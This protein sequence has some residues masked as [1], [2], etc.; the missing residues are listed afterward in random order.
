MDLHLYKQVLDSIPD[1]VTVQDKDFNVI[2]QNDAMI[3]AFGDCVGKKCY[4]CYEKRDEICDGCGVS[5]AFETK[6]TTIV[7]RTAFEKDGSTSYWE[8]ACEPLFDS[9]GNIIAGVE[10]CRNITDRVSLESAVKER[11]IKLGQVNKQLKNQTVSLES[12]M[13]EL[14]ETQAQLIELSRQA[15][16]AEVAVGILH[17]LGNSLNSVNVSVSFILEKLDDAQ[18]INLNKVIDLLKEHEDDIGTF[19]K[20]D[21]KGKHVLPFLTS[22]GNHICG[23]QNAIRTE[24]IGLLKNIEHIKNIVLMQQDYASTS[25]FVEK[26]DVKEL[27]EDALHLTEEALVRHRVPVNRKYEAVPLITVHKHMVLQILVNLIN[28]AKYAM[29]E[30]NAELRCM[31]ICVGH[32]QNGSVRIS[33][34]DSGI[35][36]EKENL[37]KIFSHGF[38]TRK[39]GH[40]FGLHVSALIA[41]DLGGSLTGYSDGVGK[42]ATFILEL[43]VECVRKQ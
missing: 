38:T 29:D 30:I 33:V 37:T 42:G 3:N 21:D 11:N 43:P 26:V 12:A 19:I 13:A 28:N 10:I 1:G 35:G 23:E 22:L 25:G 39:S 34:S 17:N 31:D 8:N 27:V 4:S 7:L 20:E 18:V 14:K 36:I 41:H 5:V 16:M 6:K 9:E 24:V 15:G 2:Y 40:G 32:G